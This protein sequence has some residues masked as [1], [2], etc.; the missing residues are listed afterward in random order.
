MEYMNR[1][2]NWQSPPLACLGHEWVHPAHDNQSITLHDWPSTVKNIK[3]DRHNDDDMGRPCE[4]S[5]FVF[6][7]WFI[8]CYGGLQKMQSNIFLYDTTKMMKISQRCIFKC[9][10]IL[11]ALLS[12]QVDLWTLK[13]LNTKV[14]VWTKLQNSHPS[15]ALYR[16]KALRTFF[17]IREH[18]FL[19]NRPLYRHTQL[20]PVEIARKD[21][22][23]WYM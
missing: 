8:F 12:T 19:S 3:E 21:N 18:S 4:L 9:H 23:Y 6:L 5:W 20:A 1:D 16:P 7:F 17:W 15:A 11:I 2:G 14:L 22:E 13:L 10:V